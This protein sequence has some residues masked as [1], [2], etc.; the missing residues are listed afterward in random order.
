M[1]S[2][3]KLYIK[4]V[5]SSS[6][7]HPNW[8]ICLHWLFNSWLLNSPKTVIW[9]QNSQSLI[10]RFEQSVLRDCLTAR[11]LSDSSFNCPILEEAVM[12]I[13]NR[14]LPLYKIPLSPLSYWW[15]KTIPLE[16]RIVTRV[17]R[18]WEFAVNKYWGRIFKV[19]DVDTHQYYQI[20]RYILGYTL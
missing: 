9:Y 10:T 4:P 18:S 13:R 7:T 17:Y 5:F 12:G 2:K 6:P 20:I 1:L 19:K 14:Y 3:Y 15:L 11:I 8:W 16:I